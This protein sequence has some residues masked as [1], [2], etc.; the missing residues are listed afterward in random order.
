MRPAF[1]PFLLA[2]FSGLTLAGQAH[3]AEGIVLPAQGPACQILRSNREEAIW[4]CPG[5][6]GAFMEYTDFVTHAGLGFGWGKRAHGPADPDDLGWRPNGSGVASRIEWR[7]TNGRPFVAIVGRWRQLEES[8]STSVF[9]ELMVI[10]LSEGEVCKVAVLGALAPD[11]MSSAR[12]IADSRAPGFHSGTDKAIENTLRPDA[13]VTVWDSHFQSREMLNHNG[14]I[15]ALTRTPDDRVEIRYIEPRKELKVPAGALLFRGTARNGKLT[16]EAFLFRPGCAPLGY[17]VAG[18]RKD[19]I[20][21][22][23]GRAPQRSPRSCEV[24]GG[25]A[26]KPSRLGFEHE[27]VL[28]LVLSVSQQTEPDTIAD[29]SRCIPAT[30]KSLEGT[31]TG[32]ARLVAQVSEDDAKS[33]CE[34]QEIEEERIT[35]CIKQNAGEIGRV[36]RTSANCTALTIEPSGGGRFR[37]YKMGEDY[38]GPAPIWIDLE[39]NEIECGARA[40]NGPSA[41]AHFALLCP[42]AIPG[43]KG[44]WAA[45]RTD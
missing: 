29:C 42:S 24:T 18:E 44:H 45:S 7:M 35:Q 15:V 33:H 21:L 22:L 6:A 38:G 2:M 4:R 43:W 25:S 31:D 39:K 14:S 1:Y 37:F 41:S 9:E 3:A 40:C 30:I 16:G 23:E 19:G 34:G 27:P 5:P 26:S 8:N 36:L 32:Q 11:A 17:P 20:L 28:Q 10:K 13:Q 12:S